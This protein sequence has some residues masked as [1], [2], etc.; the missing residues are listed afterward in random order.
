MSYESGSHLYLHVFSVILS[1]SST[2]R[3]PFASSPGLLPSVLS[4]VLSLSAEDQVCKHPSPPSMLLCHKDT[5][6]PYVISLRLMCVCV[7]VYMSWVV[8]GHLTTDITPLPL[9]QDLKPGDVTSKRN[10][11]ENKGSSATKVTKH[12]FPPISPTHSLA[13]LVI[14]THNIFHMPLENELIKHVFVQ[15][16]RLWVFTALQAYH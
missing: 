7:C 5:D 12:H 8:Q 10:L 15:T 2:V 13:L 16:N 6:I 4:S 11:W 9:L 3:F 1:F 14:Y